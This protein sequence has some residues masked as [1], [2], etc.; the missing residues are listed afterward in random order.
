MA[1]E[2]VHYPVLYLYIVCMQH[3]IYTPT[4]ALLQGITT[5]IIIFKPRN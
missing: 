1:E 4:S 5:A 3:C 2:K